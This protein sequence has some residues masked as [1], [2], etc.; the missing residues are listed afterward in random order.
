MRVGV[1]CLKCLQICLRVSWKIQRFERA[2]HHWHDKRSNR[3]TRAS[4]ITSAT[5]KNFGLGCFWH[6]VNTCQKSP[7]QPWQGPVKV[8]K[9]PHYLSCLM[10]PWLSPR[11]SPIN[12]CQKSWVRQT[13]VMWFYSNSSLLFHFLVILYF[14]FVLL[15]IWNDCR[16]TSDI[17]RI[18]V[19]SNSYAELWHLLLSDMLENTISSNSHFMTSTAVCTTVCTRVHAN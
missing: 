19:E 13:D 3:S 4:Q 14:N 6:P 11:W 15:L 5:C 12:P 16:Q 7:K 8:I 2:W 9:Y 1:P 10:C 18:I 17:V